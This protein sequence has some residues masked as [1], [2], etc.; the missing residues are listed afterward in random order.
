MRIL[1]YIKYRKSF[2]VGFLAK[3]VEVILEL[4][5]PVFMAMLIEDS[6]KGGDNPIGYL[7]VGLILIFA[8]LG[9]LSTLFA[10][11]LTAKVSQDFAKNLRQAIFYQVEELSIEDTNG[12]SSSSLINRLNLDVSH[13]QNSLAMTMRLA[14]RAPVLMVGSIIMLFI[15]SPKVALILIIGLPILITLLVGIM[16]IS[17]RI[18]QKFQVE[19]DKLVDV[20]KDN[21]EGVRMIRAFAQVEHENE[22]FEKRNSTLSQIMERLG[23]ITSLSSPFTTLAMNVLLVIMIYFGSRDINLG[24]MK[25]AELIQIINYT[26][27]LTLSIIGVMNLI[28]MYTKMYSAAI[29]VNEI[30]DKTNSITDNDNPL[31]L[32]NEPAK[33]EFKDVSFS[34]SDNTGN[35][36]NNI[37]ITINPGETIGVVGLTGSGKTTIIDLLMRF[38]DVKSGEIL[39]NDINIKDYS[40]ESLREN[41]AYAS[42]KASLLTGD[43]KENILMNDT[44]DDEAIKK[45]LVESQASFILNRPDSINSVV[46]KE[47][48]NYSGGQRQRIALAR[49][50]VKDSAILVLD[51]VF[52]A[53]DYMTDFRIRQELS[54][55]EIKQ[56]KIFISQRLSSLVNADK[57]IVLD[58]GQIT[59][60]DNHQNLIVNNPLYK[61]LHESQIG[62]EN[63]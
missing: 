53:L 62:G 50:L 14:S 36:L 47:G 22:R 32:T 56:T 10:H 11:K 15:V 35:V 45:A 16:Y 3:T 49:A 55:R 29:R 26:T 19:N 25:Q 46:L 61:A 48:V 28:L 4:F 31:V 40:L 43:V 44:Y 6:L 27:Q 37:N 17:M 20:V 60:F 5:L 7:M 39:I 59:G 54:K 21:V 58:N 42:Q 34:Y 52:S 8:V 41:I 2:V 13:L 12:F 24:T 38:F 51:D 1:R 57:I 23:R 63:L 18:F 30:L 33:I 9:Y